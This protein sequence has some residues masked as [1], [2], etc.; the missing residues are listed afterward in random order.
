MQALKCLALYCLAITPAFALVGI[1]NGTIVQPGASDHYPYIA[2][3][4]GSDMPDES[5]YAFDAHDC[6][7]TFISH[8]W[9]LTAAHCVTNVF[10]DDEDQKL[11]NRLLGPNSSYVYYAGD[12]ATNLKAGKFKRYYIDKVIIPK[13]FMPNQQQCR[14]LPG[15]YSMLK[16]NFGYDIAL[17]HVSVP[18]NDAIKTADLPTT[19]VGSRL[20]VLTAGWANEFDD[21]TSDLKEGNSSTMNAKDVAAIVS[22]S[23]L[24]QPPGF[25]YDPS[26]SFLTDSSLDSH[27]KPLAQNQFIQD[28]DSGGP[29]VLASS[30]NVIQGI[31]SGG[32]VD[33]ESY[34]RYTSVYSHLNWINAC[35]AGSSDCSQD[36]IIRSVAYRFNI[37]ND[38]D[39]TCH[40]ADSKSVSKIVSCVK[41]NEGKDV[42]VGASESFYQGSDPSV[43]N[44]PTLSIISKQPSQNQKTIGIRSDHM[45]YIDENIDHLP[46]STADSG[47]IM[48]NADDAVKQKIKQLFVVKT[49]DNKYGVT[50]DNPTQSQQ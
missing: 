8:S 41:T 15:G 6:A 29:I 28:G 32:M 10:C 30:P 35:M 7:G 1:H 36:S 16:F 33:N 3:I 45:I 25:P 5:A 24:F 19:P 49:D 39:Y 22:Q 42:D 23:P 17:L 26:H 46:V 12:Q 47:T 43:K 31:V 18:A 9:V 37:A 44:F 14:P 20:D 40:L 27:Q 38:T 21:K 34:E 50:S 48:I 13:Q 2:D 11:V 4:T